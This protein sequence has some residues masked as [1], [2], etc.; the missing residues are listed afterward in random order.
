[1]LLLLGVA[2]LCVAGW[3]VQGALPLPENG[4]ALDFGKVLD[5]ALVAAALGLFLL[6]NGAVLL[7]KGSGRP[8]PWTDDQL[9]ERL[10]AIAPWLVCLDCRLPVDVPPC[11]GCGQRSSCLEVRTDADRDNA[12]VLLGLI[13]ADAVSLASSGGGR[14]DEGDPASH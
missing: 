2:A 6:V 5:F 4:G 1:M 3:V 10:A 7:I 13:S 12:R 8:A 14:G 11:S 9:R